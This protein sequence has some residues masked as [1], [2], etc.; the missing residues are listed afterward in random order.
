[1]SLFIDQRRARRLERAEGAAGAG[2]VAVRQRVAPEAG[3]EWRDFDGTYAMY[4]G[5][6]SPMTQTFGLGMFAPAVPEQLDAIERFFHE[7]GADAQHE[8][9]PLAGVEALALLVDRGYRP[10]ELRSVLG[11]TGW[12]RACAERTSTSA[13]SRP[14]SRGGPPARSTEARWRRSRAR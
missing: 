6:E 4:D 3:A 13:G 5:A 2:F 8:V 11:R 7:R 14:R 1:M 10:I 9:S 12:S